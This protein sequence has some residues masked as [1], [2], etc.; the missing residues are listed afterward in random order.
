MAVSDEITDECVR[1]RAFQMRSLS[2]VKFCV[3]ISYEVANV[4]IRL[5]VGISGIITH[6]T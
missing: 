4:C 2:C 5:F 1:L 3:G 6:I